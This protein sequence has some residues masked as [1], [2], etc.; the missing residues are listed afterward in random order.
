VT[1][2]FGYDA[3]GNRVS[4]TSGSVTTVYPSKYYSVI[5]NGTAG[6]STEYVYSGDTLLS[7]IDRRLVSGVATG[8]AQM[9]YIHPDILG[10]TAV[11]SNASGTVAEAI[12]YF[13]YGA[14]R[15]DTNVGGI[16]EGRKYIGQFSDNSGLSY[17]NARYY[18]GTQGQFLSEDPTFLAIGDPDNLKK[19]TGK[20]Q[21]A[22]L[23]DPQLAN[24]YSYGR[25]N[26]ITQKDPSGNI[27]VGVIV[28]IGGA[29]LAADNAAPYFHRA[30][31]MSSARKNGDQSITSNDVSEQLRNAAMKLYE[32]PV[33]VALPS[34]VS[35]VL[36]L[37]GYYD[38]IK[39]IY[40]SIKESGQK[41]EPARN[42]TIQNNTAS[43]SKTSGT[44]QFWTTPSGAV[45]SG[46]GTLVSGPTKHGK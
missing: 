17:L 44:G 14:T 22:F 37:K 25:D 31:E 7:T 35:E 11:I 20:N 24:S 18:S 21:Q 45:V 46:N 26:P 4:Q 28:I 43:P 15:L 5:T 42:Q 19:I 36:D 39:E 13:P 34:H 32:F 16:V 30:I 10:S 2:T 6:T 1:T 27:E 23:A 29:L 38:K 12:D 41:G 40:Q 8:T 9:R 3:S 33:S